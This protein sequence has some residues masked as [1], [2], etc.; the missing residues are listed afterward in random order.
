MVC[1]TVSPH[2]PGGEE[3]P[4]PVKLNPVCPSCGTPAAGRYCSQCG[5]RFLQPDDFDLRHFLVEHVGHE[6]LDLDGKLLRTLRVLIARPGQIA[7]DYVAG[8]RRLYVSPLRLYLVTFILHAF[9][10]NALALHPQSLSER[11][12]M[13]DH[14]A[15]VLHPGF[16]KRLM[17]SRSSIDWSSPA[18]RDNLMER[19]HWISEAA[20]LLVFLGTAAIQKLVLLRLK[21]R[22]IEHLML[23]MNVMAFY[24]LLSVAGDIIAVLG[25]HQQME[26]ASTNIG[27]LIVVSALP[28]YWVLSLRRF[29]GIGWFAAVA[30]AGV[31]T[32]GTAVIA[33]ELNIGILA[34]IVLTS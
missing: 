34:L 3:M 16:L 32:A 15:I 4:A 24:L 29:Y 33:T 7:L 28:L 14:S 22:Y 26:A 25:W 23:T 21:R 13:L 1:A 20:T 2:D 19:V 31:L 6:M 17:V 11:A 12:E 18:S 5:E 30:V 10:L 8:R 27:S 9:L